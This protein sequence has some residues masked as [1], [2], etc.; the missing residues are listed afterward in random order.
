MLLLLTLPEKTPK[1]HVLRDVFPPAKPGFDL[2]IYKT[3]IWLTDFI[4]DFRWCGGFVRGYKPGFRKVRR[5]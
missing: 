4:A 1:T 5:T 2:K 3:R